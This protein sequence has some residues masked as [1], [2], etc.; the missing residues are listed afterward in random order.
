MLAAGQSQL[1]VALRGG[2]TGL[3]S[4]HRHKG[5]VVIG[6]SRQTMSDQLVK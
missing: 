6:K 1:G 4:H 5:K 3:P 2:A